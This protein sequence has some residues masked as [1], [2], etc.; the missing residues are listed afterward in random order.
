[1][2]KRWCFVSF[3]NYVCLR[4]IVHSC[5]KI[6][7]YL[8]TCWVKGGTLL[9]ETQFT[10]YNN[11]LW[12]HLT[13]VNQLLVLLRSLKK[14]LSGNYAKFDCYNI[15]KEK[16]ASDGLAWSFASWVCE[17]D[18]S[19]NRLYFVSWWLYFSQFDSC[20][21]ACQLVSWLHQKSSLAE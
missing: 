14:P 13:S 4:S 1:M 2:W 19:W 10:N 8:V 3:L 15:Q 6:T 18:H 5:F 11:V 9:A 7:R 17:D 21:F 12:N 20:L 16:D